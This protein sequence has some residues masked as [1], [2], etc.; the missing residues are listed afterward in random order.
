M[1]QRAASVYIT[2]DPLK[3][4][5]PRCS[6]QLAFSSPS[7]L[8]LAFFVLRWPVGTRFP[9]SH[10]PPPR[11]TKFDPPH[12]HTAWEGP[13][14]TLRSARPRD[15]PWRPEGQNSSELQLQRKKASK[16]N[17]YQRRDNY[18]TAT[19]SFRDKTL[20]SNLH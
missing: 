18:R 1:D 14:D 9:S 12:T 2:L 4:R 19:H 6:L 10:A 5:E 16:S 20:A 3:L 15:T 8:Q 7:S 13:R 11:P 17:Q